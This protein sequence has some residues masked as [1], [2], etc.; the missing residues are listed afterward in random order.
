MTPVHENR[1][2][3]FF[4]EGRYV[5]LKNHLYNYKL[6]KRAVENVLARERFDLIL[7]VGS[8]I[9]PV[10]TSTDRIVYSDISF[11][12]CRTLKRLHGKGW[13]VAA[14]MTHL[15][16]RADAFSHAVCSEVIEHIE[17]DRAALGEIARVLKARGRLIL[18]FPHRK[19]YFAND[20]RYVKHYRRYE[21]EETD[22]LLRD[23]QL[24]PLATRNVLGPLEKVTMMFAVLFFENL[25]KFADANQFAKP[26]TT[27]RLLSPVFKLANL[28]YAALLRFEAFV[29]PQR[30]AAVLLTTAE[31]R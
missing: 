12:A 2:Q 30:W 5:G 6:R 13:Y 24:Y 31:K 11:L 21:I 26:H 20:D 4:E 29:I 9:S 23:A 27:M 22:R 7:E 15:P 17:D 28:A 14:D 19:A 16:F 8:G 10:M 1:F 25:I 18:T 3:D